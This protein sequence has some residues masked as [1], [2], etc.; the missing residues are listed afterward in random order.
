MG[1]LVAMYVI[2]TAMPRT[3]W[4]HVQVGGLFDQNLYQNTVT[5]YVDAKTTKAHPF[6]Y[7]KKVITAIE[8]NNQPIHNT[9]SFQILFH[10]PFSKRKFSR[11]SKKS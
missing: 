10:V 3:C 6:E 5:K 8:M 11:F 9:I 4:N 7:R 2:M 1:W